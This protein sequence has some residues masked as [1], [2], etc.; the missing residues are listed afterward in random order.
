MNR[1]ELSLV[2]IGFGHVA[3]RFVSLLDEV[4]DRLDFSWNSSGRDQHQAAWL[5]SG[6]D[7]Q[8]MPWSKLSRRPP[9]ATPRERA[10]SKWTA[11]RDALSDEA[12]R[13]LICVETTV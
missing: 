11:S 12:R 7:M 9:D 13:P 8:G 5:T 6:I 10:S 2:L 1:P 4:A 3:R